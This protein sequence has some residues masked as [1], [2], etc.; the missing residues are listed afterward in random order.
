MP[1]PVANRWPERVRPVPLVYAAVAIFGVISGFLLN[2]FGS[3]YPVETVLVAILLCGVAT[4][5]WA[6][7]RMLRDAARQVDELLDDEL[8]RRES[9]S[10]RGA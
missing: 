7:A 8:G 1:L 9:R 2:E 5:C 3:R 6:G 10:D 4:L